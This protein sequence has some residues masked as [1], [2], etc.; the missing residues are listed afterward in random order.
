MKVTQRLSATGQKVSATLSMTTYYSNR[1]WSLEGDSI[2][3]GSNAGVPNSSQSF[4]VV[5]SKNLLA[6]VESILV[7]S[8]ATTLKSVPDSMSDCI[9]VRLPSDS[10]ITAPCFKKDAARRNLL[11][12]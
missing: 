12:I 9:S 2:P 10:T 7:H 4:G 5:K 6:S 1:P 11:G 8:V 3:V